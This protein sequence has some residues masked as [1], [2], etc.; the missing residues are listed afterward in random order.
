LKELDLSGNGLTHLPDDM[1]FL[2]SLETLTLRH[3]ALSST[4]SIFNPNKYFLAF[5]SL[6]RLKRLD[7]SHNQ[8]QGL[9]LEELLLK[10]NTHSIFKT[11]VELDMSFNLIER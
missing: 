8:L 9:H 11:L 5:A 6:P 1:S 3:N 7:L 10:K 4:T 2:S